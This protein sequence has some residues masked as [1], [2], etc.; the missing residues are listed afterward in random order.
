MD[1]RRPVRG[2]SE[3]TVARACG[4]PSPSGV[5]FGSASSVSSAPLFCVLPDADFEGITDAEPPAG[6][7]LV[8]LPGDLVEPV[9]G[10]LVAGD[11]R[12]LLPGEEAGEPFFE[13]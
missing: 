2:L 5:A 10:D 9:A 4:L 7:T 12:E 3:S 8:P 11:L 6:G 13:N 1:P